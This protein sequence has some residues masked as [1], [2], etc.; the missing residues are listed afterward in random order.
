LDDDHQEAA[1]RRL[2]TAFADD[3]RVTLGGNPVAN[4]EISKTI[5]DDLRRAELPAGGR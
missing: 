1:G 2:L 4:H 5:E 3:R